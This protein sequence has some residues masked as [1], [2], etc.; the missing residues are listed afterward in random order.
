MNSIYGSNDKKKFL[1]LQ[2]LNQG[3]KKQNNSMLLLSDFRYD[4]YKVHKLAENFKF[5]RKKY[6]IYLGMS[7]DATKKF[8][9]ES[10]NPFLYNEWIVACCGIIG[11][12]KDIIDINDAKKD[13]SILQS[14]TIA[15][16]LDYVSSQI[17]EP[18]ATIVS[19]A[20]SLVE[21]KYAVW[22]NNCDNGNVFL[23][24]CNHELYADIYENTFSCKQ[25]KGLEP[26]HDGEVYQLTKEGITHVSTF[27]CFHH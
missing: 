23:A 17:D 10:M 24:K 16:L 9:P 11:N 18:D 15:A 8:E 13:D 6:N 26:L 21:G 7:E 5:P 20:L 22:I 14:E 25:T 3:R 2:K 27:D 1:E 19:E 4:V 12:K